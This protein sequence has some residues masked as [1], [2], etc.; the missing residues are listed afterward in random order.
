M[1]LFRKLISLFLAFCL[2]A[3]LFPAGF[4]AAAAAGKIIEVKNDGDP[5]NLRKAVA[6]ASDGDTIRIL[7]VG[8]VNCVSYDGSTGTSDPWVI[9]KEVTIT[10]GTVVLRTG[11]VILDADV[12]LDGVTINVSN[13][14]RN[15]ILANGHT[16]VLK[17]VKLERNSWDLHVFCG[18]MT[19]SGADPRFQIPAPGANGKVV[20]RGAT[21]L[22]GNDGLG[23]L[24]AGSISTDGSS[25]SFAGTASIVIDRSATGKVGKIY[26]CGALETPVSGNWF[27]YVAGGAKVVPPTPSAARYKAAGNVSIDLY[28]SA[29]SSVDGAT[30]GPQNAAVTFAS[31]NDHEIALDLTNLGS[32]KITS[33]TLH[34]SRLTG[35]GMDLAVSDGGLLRLYNTPSLPEIHSFAGGGKLT[36][37]QNQTLFISGPVTGKTQVFSDGE[38][39]DGFSRNLRDGHTYLTAAQ[40]QAD[41]FTLMPSQKNPGSKFLYSPPESGSGPGKWTASTGGAI[42]ILVKSLTLEEEATVVRDNAVAIGL[43]LNAVFADNGASSLTMAALPL[44]ISVN[45]QPAEV[46]TDGYGDDLYSISSGGAV[47]L[48]MFISPGSVDSPDVLCVMGADEYTAPAAGVYEIAITVPAASTESGAAL[49]K[50]IRLTVTDPIP[51]T[52]V[53]I[54]VPQAV[55]GLRYNGQEQTGVFPGF[56]YTLTGHTGVAT[57]PYTSVAQL[58]DDTQ[59]QWADG[60]TGPQSI[61]WS[62]GKAKGPEPPENLTAA[63][64]AAASGNGKL[65]GTDT[66]MEYASD[67][68]F[69]APSGCD[70]FETA[71]APGDYYVRW[72]ETPTREA[73]A[74]VKVTI[75]AYSAPVG[76]SGIQINSTAHKT[77]YL[78]GDKLD[79]SNLTI[80]VSMTDNATAY[81]IPVTADMV[82]GFD[83]TQAAASQTLTIKYNGQYSAVY[84]VQIQSKPAVTPPSGGG[85][86]VPVE[87]GP[88]EKPEFPEDGCLG[89]DTCP[90]RGFDDLNAGAWYHDGLH[91][92]LANNLMNGYGNRRFG[93]GDTLS[94]AQLVQILYTLDGKPDPGQN[95]GFTDVKVGAWYQKAVFWAAEQKI[96]SGYDSRSFGPNDPVTREQMAAVLYRYARYKGR[97]IAP[98]GTENLSGFPDAGKV[99][100]WSTAPM[101]WAC[102]AGLISG[103]GGGRLD[104]QGK[105]TRAQAA[106]V[107]QRFCELDSGSIEK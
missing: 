88:A 103:T 2:A 25:N 90:L 10:G 92:C 8:R 76:I 85:P 35:E 34:P 45:G 98:S 16:L 60:T 15:A 32:L 40:N 30:G 91:Y 80:L 26:A 55:T 97:E 7:E 87:P 49:S 3:S 100:S 5:D 36:L 74:S 96:V 1:K 104:P 28:D 31:G 19:G 95:P 107:L 102:G 56:G 50:T 47:I 46:S 99:S 41:D 82:T 81:T 63:A 67:P 53:K 38:T 13:P 101:A 86:A 84:T 52:P 75:P 57:G 83:S 12:T 29:A 39:V 9:D 37:G 48:S 24:Y 14:V 11:G 66:N 71:L 89:G 23:N 20:I 59:Y 69:T 62:I 93:P 79:V 33:C 51:G 72:K 4:P 22:K 21:Q 73:G 65:M 43:P 44:E 54:P 68:A 105:A 18:G 6:A 70:A 17:D 77:S 106:S 94:R 64:P 78:V 61:S 27:D 42:P 58:D